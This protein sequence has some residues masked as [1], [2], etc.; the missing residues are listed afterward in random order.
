VQPIFFKKGNTEQT[1][2]YALHCS[3]GVFGQDMEGIDVE[4]LHPERWSKKRPKQ[5]EYVPF[6][7]GQ[8]SCVWKEGL[9]QNQPLLFVDWHGILNVWR[10]VMQSLEATTNT[11]CEQCEWV[12]GCSARIR[13][14]EA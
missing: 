14:I 5:W 8:R 4:V 3:L 2:F 1:S 6:G 13:A 12:Q 9:S 7:G 11:H 10:V